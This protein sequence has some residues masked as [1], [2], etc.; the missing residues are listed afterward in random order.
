MAAVG[1]PFQA[2]EVARNARL[3]SL[4][5]VK[6][7][8][9]PAACQVFGHTLQ[10]TETMLAAQAHPLGRGMKPCKLR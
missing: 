8:R 1:Q 3:E 4:T 6:P 9:F 7:N 10:G 2:D 5:Y